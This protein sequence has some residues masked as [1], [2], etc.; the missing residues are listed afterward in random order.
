MQSRVL[1]QSACSGDETAP[2]CFLPA[3]ATRSF[4]AQRRLAPVGLTEQ[5]KRPI[6]FQAALQEDLMG[7]PKGTVVPVKL[8]LSPSWARDDGGWRHNIHSIPMRRPGY[9]WV[10]SLGSYSYLIKA[11]VAC[12][13]GMPGAE[14]LDLHSVCLQHF[15]SPESCLGSA[16]CQWKCASRPC[17]WSMWSHTICTYD[18]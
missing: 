6:Q 13:T 15:L 4:I 1:T 5:Q 8:D 11:P 12:A 18:T 14:P 17:S 2:S 10:L 9:V 7:T 3:A 16:G